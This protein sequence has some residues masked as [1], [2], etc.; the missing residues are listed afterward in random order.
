MKLTWVALALLTISHFV[1][2]SCKARN[3]NSSEVFVDTSRGGVVL[4]A[5]IADGLIRVP[6]GL[7]DETTI[8]RKI[9]AQLSYTL[10]NLAHFHGS[11]DVGRNSIELLPAP[12]KESDAAQPWREVRYKTTLVVVLPKDVASLANFTFVLPVAVEEFNRDEIYSFFNLKFFY[13]FREACLAADGIGKPEYK[14]WNYF[15][16]RK[17]GCP[18][19]DLLLNGP[20]STGIVP[21]L[22]KNYEVLLLTA[23]LKPSTSA[24]AGKKPEYRQIWSDG[25]LKV[26]MVYTII[27]E[28][29]AKEWAYISP[30]NALHK[31]RRAHGLPIRTDET[32]PVDPASFDYLE[33]YQQYYERIEKSGYIKSTI[34]F[35]TSGAGGIEFH[36]FI[37]NGLKNADSWTDEWIK[38]KDRIAAV[39]PDVD[40]YGFVGHANLG[41]NVRG[42]LSLPTYQKEKYSIGLFAACNSFM[43]VNE[44]MAA[45]NQEL[46]P[47]TKWT[48][49]FDVISAGTESTAGSDSEDL[50]AL[51]KGLVDRRLTYRQILDNFEPTQGPVVFGEEDNVEP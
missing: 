8:R 26:V 20:K 7:T 35:P 1:T 46:N 47:G 11:A 37:V 42:F 4:D 17:E 30:Y 25:K 49:Y 32:A 38:L 21:V 36:M 16:P 41:K 18:L 29:V 28:K 45:I 40:L 51:I 27:K 2:F 44:G 48:K 5:E 6:K 23:A 14:F 19:A 12:E 24:T 3:R 15:A 13:E 10:A 43:F 9:Y 31:V 33:T 22:P 34:P 50:P 39:G